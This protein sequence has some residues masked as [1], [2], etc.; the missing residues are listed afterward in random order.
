DQ[1]HCPI[2][3]NVFSVDVDLAK[4]AHKSIHPE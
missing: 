2:H 1:G 3:F 4:V